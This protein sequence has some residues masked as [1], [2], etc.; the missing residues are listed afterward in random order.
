MHIS[1]EI[2]YIQPKRNE[3]KKSHKVFPSVLTVYVI[4][5]VFISPYQ[6]K[7]NYPKNVP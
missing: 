1:S 7:K 4:T 3:L 5:M 2:K 6:L